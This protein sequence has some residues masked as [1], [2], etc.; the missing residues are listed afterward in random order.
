MLPIYLASASPRRKE[1][2]KQLI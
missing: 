1:L 2:L